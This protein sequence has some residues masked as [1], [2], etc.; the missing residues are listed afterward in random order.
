MYYNVVAFLI[1]EV[2]K[3]DFLF[4]KIRLPQISFVPLV[5]PK[6]NHA[7]TLNDMCSDPDSIQ[8]LALESSLK[9]L[10][11]TRSQPRSQDSEQELRSYLSRVL[12][13]AI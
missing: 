10:L 8:D 7:A 2:L 1:A 3:P 9:S 13:K 4:G 11:P 6:E 5:T 12:Q